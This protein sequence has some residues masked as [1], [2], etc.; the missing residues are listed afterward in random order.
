VRARQRTAGQC[1]SRNAWNMKKYHCFAGTNSFSATLN[2]IQREFPSP[3]C[4]RAD[5]PPNGPASSPKRK[6][7]TGS[8]AVGKNVFLVCKYLPIFAAKSLGASCCFYCNIA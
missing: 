1:T 3:Q 8:K 2:Q 7:P 4:L 6:A 5:L